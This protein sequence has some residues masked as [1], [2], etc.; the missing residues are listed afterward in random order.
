MK[1]ETK[2]KKNEIPVPKPKPVERRNSFA[3]IIITLLVLMVLSIIIAWVLSGSMET[4]ILATGNVAVIPVKGV[5]VTEKGQSLFASDEADSK[6]LIRQ[7]KDI[8]KNPGIKAVIFE[9]NSPGG[10]AVASEEVASAVKSLKKYKVAVIRETGTSGAYWVASAC[11][12][13]VASRMSI[14]G[15]IGVISSYLDFAGLLERY[16]VTY[17]RLVS[18]SY[19]DIGT[20]YR[21]LTPDEEKLLQKKIDMI[22]SY[23][24][25]SVA[26]N[27]K[28]PVEKM[29]ELSTGMFFLGFEAKELGL[30]DEIGG[31]E[32]A[33]ELIKAEL[34]LENVNIVEVSSKMGFFENLAGLTS[35]FR[36][37]PSEYTHNEIL[38]IW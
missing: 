2:I 1:A 37:L 15:S 16:N 8:E 13:I 11:D 28:M 20:P 27:R 10:S 26:S 18:G 32:E 5:I 4:P 38:L 24:V 19:K 22:H 17:Q 12:K 35:R 7:I 36:F 33:V 14:T 25:D 6:T 30:V 3:I 29:K 23:F 21:H 34:K 31:R 9:I